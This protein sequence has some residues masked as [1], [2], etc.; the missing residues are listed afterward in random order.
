MGVYNIRIIDEM[1]LLNRKYY[2][3]LCEG[4][5]E[6]GY[7]DKLM[8]W[9]YSRVDTVRRPEILK[10]VREA[11]IR[12]LGI[13]IE[14]GD[15]EVRLEVSKGKFK[16]VDIK[17]VVRKV[18]EAGINVMANYIFGLPTD[19]QESMQKTLDLAVDLATLGWNGYAA[20]PLP[21]S[22]LYKDAL[23]AGYKLP[24]EYEGFSFHSYTTTPIPTDNLTSKEILKFR[25]DA[26]TTY[27]TSEKFLNKVKKKYGQ[28]A[29]DNIL[30]NTKIK[31]KRKLLGD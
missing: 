15:R 20:M 25:D 19:T 29:V 26:Y 16:D 31:L 12:W 5:I 17:Q 2:Q 8:M 18:E 3:P 4:L 24:K 7:G 28:G 14:S 6:R 1:F 30:K 13:G 23:E 22:Q 21:G 10:L 9:A 11:G 27:H